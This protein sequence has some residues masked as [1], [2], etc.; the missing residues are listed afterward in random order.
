MYGQE[1]IKTSFQE[2]KEVHKSSAIKRNLLNS[3][4]ELDEPTDNSHFWSDKVKDSTK[5]YKIDQNI[6][7]FEESLSPMKLISQPADSNPFSI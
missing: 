6:T 2:A 5:S 1:A 3:F 7:K 4:Y